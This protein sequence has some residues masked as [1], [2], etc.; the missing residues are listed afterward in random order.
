MP[1]IL[2]INGFRFYF[3]AGDRNEPAHVHVERGDGIG[4]IWLGLS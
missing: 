3:Y 2:L 4:K 1:T